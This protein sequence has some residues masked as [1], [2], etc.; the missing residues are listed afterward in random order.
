M[1]EKINPGSYKQSFYEKEYR[2]I[3]KVDIKQITDLFNLVANMN[4][5]D[6]KQYMLIEQIPYNVVDNNG[7]TLIHRVLLENDILKTENQRLHMIKY[8]YN[9]N[10][11]PDSPNNLNLTPLH[12]ACIKQYYN[13]IKY[14]IDIGVDIN[15]QDNY[16][17]TP[18][19]RLFSG[20]I[21]PEEKTTIGQLVPIPKKQDLFNMEKWKNERIKIWDAIKD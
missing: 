6:V 16:G 19:H 18:L 5:N 3:I 4:I 17:N 1:T 11:N 7:N 14:L 9:E 8:L 15:Y 2:P 10:V 21:K 13:I 20:N 12:L